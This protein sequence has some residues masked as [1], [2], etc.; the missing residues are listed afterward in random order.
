MRNMWGARYHPDKPEADSTRFIS[1]FDE[2]TTVDDVYAHDWPSPDALDYGGI[3][4]QCEKYAD[5]YA[6][7]GSPWCPFF[8]EVGWLIGQEPYFIWMH[9]K[10]DVVDAIT[11]CIVSYEIEVTRRFLEAC[12]GK[13]DIAFFGNDFGSQRGLVISPAMWERFLRKPLKRYFDLSHDFGC[14][15]MKH[16][17]GAIRDIIPWF[18]EDG[19]DALDPVQ[20]RAAGMDFAGLVR[21]YGA[22]L[23][24][25]GGVDTQHTLPFGSTDDV[26][27]QVRGYRELT[28]DRGGY[29]MTGSQSLIEDIPLDNI[30]AMYE[31]NA[32]R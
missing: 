24:L 13:L 25:H 19:V 15:V 7:Y 20:V 17:C 3:G 18:I 12:D 4:E 16:C 30:L 29:I 14:L 8:H 9:T 21:D 32:R 2:G 22:Q 26:R 23:A 28:R 10:P 6:T 1:P 11:D 27:A 5:T 31:E